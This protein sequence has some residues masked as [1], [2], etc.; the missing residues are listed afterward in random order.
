MN[1]FSKKS[2]R[3]LS[4]CHADLQTLFQIVIKHWDCTVTW[5]HR[6]E[7]DQNQA[8]K[9]GFSKLKYPDSKHNKRPSFAVDVVP[10]P[11]LYSDRGEMMR[12]GNFVMGVATMLKQYGAIDH[13]VTWGGNW[14]WK[15]YP[16][17]QI[18]ST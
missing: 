1:K 10:Y 6:G 14:N 13:R 18:N 4:E 5:G 2:S 11:T 7:E 3:K 16:H 12:F 8:Y 17:F 9:D 15:D